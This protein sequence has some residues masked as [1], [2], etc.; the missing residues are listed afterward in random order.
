MGPKG[1]PGTS[2]KRGPTGRP[3]KRGKQVRTTLFW[4][5]TDFCNSSTLA[6]IFFNMSL[7]CVFSIGVP[8]GVKGDFGRVGPSGPAGP[9]GS[10]GQPGPP[11]LPATGL[12]THGSRAF[13]LFLGLM[14]QKMICLAYVCD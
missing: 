5:H 4:Y 7:C 10:P 11:G 14:R 13:T 12:L 3:G 2:G 8:Q 6:F 1:E 9:Q